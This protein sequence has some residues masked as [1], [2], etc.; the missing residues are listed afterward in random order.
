MERKLT[1]IIAADVV[2][3]SILIG[4]DEVGTLTALT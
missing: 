4:Q 3:Y 1:A 2:N